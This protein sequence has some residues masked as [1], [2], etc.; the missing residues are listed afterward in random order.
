[1]I[2]NKLKAAVFGLGICLCA[3]ML[4]A[5]N[6]ENKSR[7]DASEVVNNPNSM[8]PGA[9]VDP[10]NAPVITFDEAEFD[11][12]TVKQGEKVNHVYTFTN[13]GKSP[14]LIQNAHASCGCTLPK[15]SRE[16]IAPGGKGEITAEFNSENKSG[17]QH[18]T[19]TVTANTNPA[20]TELSLEGEV[21]APEGE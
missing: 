21:E 15:W 7:L 2:V 11:F 8:E 10:E 16:P 4:G 3:G 9:P 17:K 12:G 5:C 14:L 1:M 6:S 13:T 18:K 19:I 20:Q